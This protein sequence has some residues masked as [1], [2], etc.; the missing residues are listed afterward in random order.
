MG[1]RDITFNFKTVI[2]TV[3]ITI[4]ISNTVGPIKKTMMIM[5]TAVQLFNY[6]HVI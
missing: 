2:V 3:I 6:F 4:L 5:I 1:V